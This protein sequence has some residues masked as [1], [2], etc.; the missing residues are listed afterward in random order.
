[1]K[2]LYTFV[3]AL[4]MGVFAASAAEPSTSGSVTSDAPTAETP[5]IKWLSGASFDIFALDR[6]NAGG[7][8][9]DA[10][11]EGYG[12]AISGGLRLPLAPR[13]YAETG[14]SLYINHW[15]I[16]ETEAVGFPSVATSVLKYGAR[17]PVLAG[18]T[19]AEYMDIKFSITAGFQLDCAFGG[20]YS[21]DFA[22][23]I[24]PVY[25]RGGLFRRFDCQAG[26]GFVLD[27]DNFYVT[28]R[29]MFGL[30]NPMADR[31]FKSRQVEVN[32]AFGI[33][34]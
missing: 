28:P 32:I 20:D 10:F 15:K 13:W 24:P 16:Q 5:R 31:N 12:G 1:M 7:T 25:G 33:V 11:R 30:L 14:L 26:F 29:A 21:E 9:Y 8:H 27:F 17:V 19:F 23:E 6:L 34:L 3:V 18:F 22:P 4:V 2:K